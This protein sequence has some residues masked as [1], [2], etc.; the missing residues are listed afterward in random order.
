MNGRLFLFVCALTVMTFGSVKG[1]NH[2]DLMLKKE[3]VP[4]LNGKDFDD[5]NRYNIVVAKVDS[6]ESVYGFEPDV[7]YRFLEASFYRGD[8]R[9][10]QSKMEILVK[11][12]GLDVALLNPSAN[13]YQSIM[14]G[15]L[16]KWF[17]AMYLKNHVVWLD[18]NFGKQSDLY[19]LNSLNEKDQVV[20]A[21]A[22]RLFFAREMD[23]V[24]KAL[25]QFHL[26]DFNRSNAKV[27]VDLSKKYQAFPTSK[28]F[29][30]I[31]HNFNNVLVHNFQQQETLDQTWDALFP[32]LKQ[33]YLNQE[34]DNTIFQNYDFYY[35][36]NYGVQVFG[37]YSIEQIPEQFRKNDEPIRLKD[38]LFYEAMKREFGW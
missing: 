2:R 36:C 30:L 33:A 34:I 12:Y 18:H 8:I 4:Y 31:Q 16:S 26:D 29:G 11:D 25:I 22:S 37:S 38:V 3:I 7:E 14:S 35:Y 17:K 23:S 20:N 5:A 9:R 32:F 13:Y 21:F 6:L 24:Q 27:L 15:Q 28:S 19:R 10:F 1:Q